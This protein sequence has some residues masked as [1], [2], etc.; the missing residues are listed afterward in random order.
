MRLV[1]LLPQREWRRNISSTFHVVS[2]CTTC[3]SHY[4]KQIVL[5]QCGINSEPTTRDYTFNVEPNACLCYHSI[6]S[7]DSWP[8]ELSDLEGDCSSVCLLIGIR[9]WVWDVEMRHNNKRAIGRVL[10][11]TFWT[12]GGGDYNV[13][14]SR[15]TQ[16]VFRPCRNYCSTWEQFDSVWLRGCEAKR[17]QWH[18][19]M[20]GFD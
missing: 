16:F 2:R 4:S 5:S 6:Y 3:V 18:R 9:I 12:G 13:S 10:I 17:V 14:S 7:T 8:E 11:D 19:E 20:K 1:T 15:K